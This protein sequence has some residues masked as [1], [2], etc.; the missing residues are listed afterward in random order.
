MKK[1]LIALATVA[2][3]AAVVPSLASAQAAA[4]ASPLTGNL[5]I[6]SD[7]RFRGISQSFRLPAV[8]GGIDW[9]H[10]SGVYLGNWNSSVSGNQYPN[11][12]SLEMDFYGGYKFPVGKDVTLDVGALYY[13][14]PGAFYN[15]FTGKPKYDNFELYFGGVMGPFSAKLFVAVTD[16]FGLDTTTGGKSSSG[17]YYVDLN[18]STEIAPKLTVGAHIGYQNVRNYSS[19]SYID[20]KLGVTYDWTG[21]LLSAAIVGSDADKN[22]YFATDSSGKIKRLGETGLV[23]SIGK[24]F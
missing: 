4:P 3:S 19:L 6:T 22:L 18:Y 24:T 9:A 7:Y 5:T 12:A 13:Y 14:Y 8:Q 20:Y 1:P 11:G 2:V 17:S 23:L 10:S 15:G 16:F 21:W